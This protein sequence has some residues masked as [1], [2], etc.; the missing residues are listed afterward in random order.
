M[1]LLG[2]TGCIVVSV[3]VCVVM[4]LSEIVWDGARGGKENGMGGGT[5]G[6][7]KEGGQHITG[8]GHLA[9]NMKMTH[10]LSTL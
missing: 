9:N 3:W 4:A 8:G 1:C 6:C 2:G 10:S 7:G 5:K